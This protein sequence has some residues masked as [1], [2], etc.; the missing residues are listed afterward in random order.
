VFQ[1]LAAGD[2]KLVIVDNVG[3]SDFIPLSKY[4][5]VFARLKIA[6]KWRRFETQLRR[7]YPG[8]KCLAHPGK[9]VAR[10]ETVQA[11]DTKRN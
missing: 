3:N 10:G 1:Q 9:S 2:G 7:Q 11:I 8:N 4:N 6:R 5:S